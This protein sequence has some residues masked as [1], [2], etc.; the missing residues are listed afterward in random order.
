MKLAR[1]SGTDSVIGAI[2]SVRKT[3]SQ[4]DLVTPAFSLFAQVGLLAASC[5]PARLVV[6]FLKKGSLKPAKRAGYAMASES[7]LP[8][9]KVRGQARI[10]QVEFERWMDDQPRGRP[11]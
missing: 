7:E 11:E 9:F 3:A 10:R 4:L 8:T 1:S 5:A 2:R 6:Y